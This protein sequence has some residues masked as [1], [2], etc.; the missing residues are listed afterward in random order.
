MSASAMNT[1]TAETTI[2]IH[3]AVSPTM[4]TSRFGGRERRFDV[5]PDGYLLGSY[6]IATA[7]EPNSGA[8]AVDQPGNSETIKHHA[9]SFRTECLLQ[10]RYNP[11]ICGKLAE[12]SL[13]IGGVVELKGQRKPLGFFIAVR[14]DVGAHQY[15]AS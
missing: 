9:E 11:A 7:P 15:V 4:T 6:R 2:G 12:H 3:S 10:R 5:Q 14:R 8:I 1:N 13:G